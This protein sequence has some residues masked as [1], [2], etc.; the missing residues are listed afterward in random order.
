RVP[1]IVSW[2]SRISPRV[3]DAPVTSMDATTTA[4]ALAS[5]AATPVHDV[6]PAADKSV[7]PTPALDGANLLPLLTS[8]RTELPDRTLF[9]RVGMKSALRNGDWKL[10]RDGKEWRLYDL[11]HDISETRNLATQ[12]PAR[13]QQMSA[14]WDKWNAE[15][16]DPLWK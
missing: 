16:I 3:I 6:A 2:K 11:T 14:L 7:R 10:I 8:K 4:L 13:V 15:Q 5:G 12:E 9:W 1:F